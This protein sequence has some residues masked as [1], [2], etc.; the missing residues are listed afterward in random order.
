MP[1]LIKHIFVSPD[2]LKRSVGT[3]NRTRKKGFAN[4][5]FTNP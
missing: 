5:S 1:D 2:N 4:F 3:L